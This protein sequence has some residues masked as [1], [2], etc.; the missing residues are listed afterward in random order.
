MNSIH[1]FAGCAKYL[2]KE[3]FVDK[4]RL[5]AIGVSAGGLL[6]GAT[7]NLHPHL[8]SAAVLKVIYFYSDV[9][10]HNFH[11]TNRQKC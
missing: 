7:I 3:G 9:P 11:C 1:D 6:V 5:G 2:I 8:F 4:D 10:F